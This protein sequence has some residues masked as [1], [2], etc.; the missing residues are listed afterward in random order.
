V[1]EPD[2]NVSCLSFWQARPQ[3]ERLL[4][5]LSLLFTFLAIGA[6]RYC[7]STVSPLPGFACPI[8]PLFVHPDDEFA[9]D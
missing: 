3:L 8:A 4:Q 6:R 5:L 2:R 9:D 7:S 1:K